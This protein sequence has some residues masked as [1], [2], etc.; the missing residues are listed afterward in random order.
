ML[1][2]SSLQL[3]YSVIK[4]R[5]LIQPRQ[6]TPLQTHHRSYVF[7]IL[8]QKTAFI[9]FSILHHSYVLLMNSTWYL[10]SILLCS[11]DSLMSNLHS[12]VGGCFCLVA[13]SCLT[14]CDPMGCSMPG[15]PVLHYVPEF[16]QTH[17]H[18][19]DDAIRPSHPLLPPS[20]FTFNLSQYHGLFQWSALCIR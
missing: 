8:I 13:H 1:T 3:I 11:I 17:V 9:E 4:G 5:N 12:Y 10:W 15:F 16:T 14:L 6:L 7:Y 19:I 20:P 18:W 2:F